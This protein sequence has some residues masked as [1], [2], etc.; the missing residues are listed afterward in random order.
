MTLDA[1]L[2]ALPRY[3][4]VATDTRDVGPGTVFVA[5]GGPAGSRAAFV[6]EAVARGAAVVVGEAALA[7]E[8]VPFV[9]VADFREAAA[10]LAAAFWGHPSRGMR[11][12]G[13]TGTCGKT[14]TTYLVEAIL[15]AAGHVVGAIGTVSFRFPGYE[16]PATNTTPGA[17]ELQRLLAE[18]REA[19]C[20]AVV[21]EVSS[22]ALK[23]KRVHGVAFDVGVFTNFSSEHLDYHKTIDDYFASKALLFSAYP[24]AAGAVGKR[25]AA[26]LNGADPA[27]A[28][29]AAT[30]PGARV[31]GGE[32]V[33]LGG[34]GVTV[35]V[36]GE[37]Y[38]CGLV[39]RFNAE[40][41]L[42]A[43]HAARALGA[44]PGAIRAGL[45]GFAQVPGRLER[46]ED[47]RGA[48]LFVDYAHKPGA[49]E[50][51]LSTLRELAGDRRL[52]VVFGCG[53][54]RDQ[55]KRP[56]MGEIAAR[57]ADAVWV[58]SDNPRTEDPD[59]I[60]AAI[61]AGMPRAEHVRVRVDRRA[62]I[63]DAVAWA[64]PGDVLVVAGKGPEPYQIVADPDAPGT[65]R[66]LSFDDRVEVA[67]AAR[68]R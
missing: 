58:T 27:V 30:M 16:R 12:V 67:A 36:E 22:H 53:G 11:V 59:A 68:E 62:A 20:T 44:A 25:F 21:M 19:G 57:L 23:Q 52:G 38:A 66:T 10:E 49:L 9:E 3:A 56:V 14:T 63:R 61:V 26:V 28:A 35:T 47:P 24:A 2:A 33:E 6:A 51:I 31:F 32:P 43:V 7:T 13:I 29:L 17:V 55:V 1:L 48:H 41:V 50:N 5:G 45:A 46:V 34:A 54:D 42:A 39:G 60:V 8:A 40:N 4:G 15:R 18:M 37:R 65:T 64:G